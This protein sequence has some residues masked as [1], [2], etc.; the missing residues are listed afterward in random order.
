MAVLT[1]WRPG[2]SRATPPQATVAVV[3]AT[4]RVQAN[5]TIVVGTRELSVGRRLAGT[6]VVVRAAGRLL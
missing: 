3:Q 2:H 1:L 6:E 5:G 4:R